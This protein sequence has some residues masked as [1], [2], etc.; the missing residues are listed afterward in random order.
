MPLLRW[1]K[2]GIL[3]GWDWT[4]PN[5]SLVSVT[6]DKDGNATD[7]SYYRYGRENREH[8]Y[9]IGPWCS[10]LLVNDVVE[11][12]GD[13]SWTADHSTRISVQMS[14]DKQ[15]MVSRFLTGK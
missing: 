4:D 12:R 6:L 9:T 1:T 14:P 3:S 11:V 2:L 15:S 8:L 5:S 10:D 13:E 7:I